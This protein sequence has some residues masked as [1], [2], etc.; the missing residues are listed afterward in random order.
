MAVDICSSALIKA[1]QQET[2]AILLRLSHF[3]RPNQARSEPNDSNQSLH[4]LRKPYFYTLFFS[5][6]YCLT[7][8]KLVWDTQGFGFGIEKYLKTFDI[9][10]N[11][12]SI[13]LWKNTLKMQFIPIMAWIQYSMLSDFCIKINFYIFGAYNQKCQGDTTVLIL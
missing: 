4:L 13:Y 2:T 12:I 9:R 5:V 11:D 6:V 3:S 7:F 8:L 10:V 1:G